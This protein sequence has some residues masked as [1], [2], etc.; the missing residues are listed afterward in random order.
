MN[1]SS[2]LTI[3]ILSIVAIFFAGTTAFAGLKLDEQ[4]QQNKE[5][6]QEIKTG[7]VHKNN[8]TAKADKA[9]S[10][11]SSQP[12]NDKGKAKHNNKVAREEY[13][14]TDIGR[15]LNKHKDTMVMPVKITDKFLPTGN[16]SIDA[17][18][19][20]DKRSRM[21][22]IVGSQQA[23]QQEKNNLINASHNNHYSWNSA[24]T[25]FTGEHSNYSQVK[26]NVLFGSSKMTDQFDFSFSQIVNAKTFRQQTIN[27][28]ILR[29]V[30]IM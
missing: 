20:T 2:K 8:N 15:Y 19:N 26:P 12:I 1:K 18:E 29:N 30:A 28:I 25:V 14:K 21:V 16:P 17:Q 9:S 6:K 27:Q 23:L 24:T 10:F 4:K 13:A 3:I 22:Y 7:F 11:S 5:L